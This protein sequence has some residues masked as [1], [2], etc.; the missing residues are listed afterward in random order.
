VEDAQ[1]LEAWRNGD[2][3][4]GQ[5]FFERHYDALHRFFANKASAEASDLVQDTLEACVSGRDRI[6]E[7]SSVRGYLFGVAYNV[8][9]RH[10][11]RQ[12]VAGERFDPDAQSV[13]DVSPG[14][15]TAMGKSEE[16]RLLLAGLRRIPLNFQVVLE[17]FYWEG[18]TSAAIADALDEPHGT[19]RTRLRRARELL[20][21]AISAAAETRDLVT[22]TVADLAGWAARVRAGL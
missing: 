18:M 16:Q 5:E 12:R 9:R 13:A 17:L 10:Y 1:L 8:L 7:S 2:R 21:E 6:R 11:E 3:S 22:R 14:P 15:G 20:Q 19:I 4:A